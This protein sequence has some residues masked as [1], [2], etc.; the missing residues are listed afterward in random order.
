MTM[1]LTGVK[2]PIPDTNKSTDGITT[3]RTVSPPIQ[4]TRWIRNGKHPNALLESMLGEA[5]NQAA[6]FRT[7]QPFSWSTIS[8][9]GGT[10][11]SAGAGSRNRWRF[12]FHTGPYT[13][14]VNV[15]VMMQ[16]QNTGLDSDAYAQLDLTNAAGTTSETFH[17]GNSP[18]ASATYGIDAMAMVQ[19]IVL[20]TPDTDYTGLFTDVDNG[21]IFSACV[22]EL[23]SLTQNFNGYLPQNFTAM[24]PIFSQYRENLATVGR[25]LWRRGAAHVLN[26]TSDVDAN[27][28]GTA[29]VTPLNILDTT[30][31]TIDPTTPGFT[32]DMTGKA[33]LSQSTGVPVVM[34]VFAN[35]AVGTGSVFFKNSAGATL[36]SIADTWTPGQSWQTVT[37]ML[38]AG[39][40]KYDIQLAGD[41]SFVFTVYAVSIYE[42]ES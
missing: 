12:A 31:S 36:M 34:R 25:N 13:Q 27:A 33:R 6:M 22:F 19:K 32:I 14:A 16:S 23:A 38:P 41:A 3:S 15:I 20:V 40:D 28:P 1:P 4:I 11:A 42:Y 37:G 39:V 21:R 35:S 7:K 24:G 26:F 29:G 8:G 10:P 17:Y 18:Y 5:M 9:A 2:A 30:V